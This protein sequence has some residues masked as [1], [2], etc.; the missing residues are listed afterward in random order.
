MQ[1]HKIIRLLPVLVLAGWLL[2]SC[3]KGIK[4]DNLPLENLSDYGVYVGDLANLEYASDVIPYD[5]NTPLFSDYSFKD[6]LIKLPEGEVIEYT[7]QD[8]F[9]FPVGTMIFKTFSYPFDFRNPEAGRRI[10]ETRVLALTEEGWQF[11][12]YEWNEAQTDASYKPVISPKVV[13]WTHYDGSA[14][15]TIYIVPNEIECGNCHAVGNTE[16]PIGPRAGNLNG[17]FDYLDGS[18]NQLQR[19]TERGWLTGTPD[20]SMVTQFAEWEDESADLDN[21]ARSYLDV[22]C[23][24]CHRPDGDANNSGLFLNYE[25]TDLTALGICKPPIATGGGSGGLFY[26]IVPGNA[27]SSIMVYRMNSVELDEAMPEIGRSIIHTEGL[28]LISEW[29][30]DM[31]PVD[32]N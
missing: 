11:Y 19:W 9:D 28:E 29:I 18:A 25:N 30:N 10:I 6:R 15:S 23:A 8:V 14:R 3:D 7:D 24:H 12:P 21:R 27:D 1:Q 5:L 20:L 16:T 31:D 22:N 26:D 32:C 17:S 4:L 13:E 2:G